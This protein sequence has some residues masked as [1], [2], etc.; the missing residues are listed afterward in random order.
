MWPWGHYDLE[1]RPYCTSAYETNTLV[2][3]AM[4]PTTEHAIA[5]R[6]IAYGVCEQFFL[7]SEAISYSGQYSIS[8]LSPHLSTVITPLVPI[9][10]Q[11]FEK[12]RLKTP[13]CPLIVTAFY[14][15]KRNN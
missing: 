15:T 1:W 12:R 13:K 8:P 11:V 2:N 4:F 5:L 9:F 7:A 6:A 3:I 10:C 14:K